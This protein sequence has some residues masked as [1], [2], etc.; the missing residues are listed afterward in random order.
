M[1]KIQQNWMAPSY[2]ANPDWRAHEYGCE[3]MP[4]L[5]LVAAML[6]RPKQDG[7][8]R[9]QCD[10]E[11]RAENAIDDACALMA[12][13]DKRLDADRAREQVEG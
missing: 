4:T 11:R 10:R 5:L 7:N 2:P 9:T 6:M 13:I 8:D 3:G 1:H 12:A